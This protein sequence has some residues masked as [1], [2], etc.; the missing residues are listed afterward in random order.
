METNHTT[1]TQDFSIA[2]FLAGSIK[3]YQEAREAFEKRVKLMV[4]LHRHQLKDIHPLNS[5][6][7]DDEMVA[8]IMEAVDTGI[9][10]VVEVRS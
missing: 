3:E 10:R 7:D 4:M 1:P 6:M 5:R 2:D 8:D 9:I